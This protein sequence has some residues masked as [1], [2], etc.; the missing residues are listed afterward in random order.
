MVVTRSRFVIACLLALSVVVAGCGTATPGA[1]PSAT[2]LGQVTPSSIPASE[3]TSSTAARNQVSPLP[4]P[5]LEPTS[6]AAALSQV[7]P[8]PTP[9]TEPTSAPQIDAVAAIQLIVLH[10][11]DNWGETEPCG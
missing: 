8:L 2:S 9:A 1:S 10:S 3:P 4:T 5:A 11:N 7:S 6:S